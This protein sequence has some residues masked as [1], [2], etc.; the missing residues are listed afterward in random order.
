MTNA[1]QPSLAAFLAG[2]TPAK[3]VGGSSNTVVGAKLADDFRNAVKDASRRAP[4][5]Q[6]VHLGPSEIGTPCSRQIAGK[7]AGVPA[8][9]HVTDPWPSTV[10]TAVHAW[11]D[12]ALSKANP[13]RWLAE[14]RVTPIRGHSGTADLY[15]VELCAVVDHKVL[16]LTSHRKVS[17]GDIGRGYYVQLLLYAL[18]YIR[19]GMRVDRVMLAAWSRGGSLND[20]YV[21]DH[22]I[23]A[24]DW[25]LLDYVLTAEL[26][27]RKLWAQ[28]IIEGN[29][30]LNDVPVESPPGNP[31]VELPIC[32]FCPFYRPEL[33]ESTPGGCPGVAGHK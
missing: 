20:L 1:E 18:G 12:T 33:K 23:T 25:Q 7:L 15:D 5:S 19:L 4:R 31:K 29:A 6:Q 11:L 27:Y 10:G 13:D 26:P 3:H 9:N 28:S 32:Y 24:E 30:T 16:G 8:T 17:Q 14:R 21:W 22:E 2:N